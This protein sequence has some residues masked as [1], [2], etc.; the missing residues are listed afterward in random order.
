VTA[1]DV[2][3]VAPGGELRVAPGALVTPWARE[4]AETRGVR[5]VEAV[6]RGRLSVAIGSDHGGF[7]LKEA[8]KRA[9]RD[10]HSV[11]DVGPA[12]ADPVDYPDYAAS[13]ARLVAS[14]QC[15][16]GVMVDAMGIGSC[17]AANKVKGARAAM[18]NDEA[19]ARNARE[20][21]DANVLTLGA[22][23]VDEARATAIVSLFLAGR[24]VEERHRK[25]VARI[26][27]IEKRG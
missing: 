21:N 5:I 2:A 7:V 13:V 11:R 14:G 12:S 16:F 9:L 18:C 17:M 25:R 19:A 8:L 4:T 23:V 26:M 6:D 15:D 20:H 22:K 3:R 1:E 24:C 10:A 27:E